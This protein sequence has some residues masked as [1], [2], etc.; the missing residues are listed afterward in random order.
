M[1]EQVVNGDVT[2]DIL[3]ASFFIALQI[4]LFSRVLRI[5]TLKLETSSSET[6]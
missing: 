5:N 3:N 4:W 2:C 1:K 6:L